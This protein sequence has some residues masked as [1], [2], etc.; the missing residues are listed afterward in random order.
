MVFYKN[1]EYPRLARID[2]LDQWEQ[3]NRRRDQE[4]GIASSTGHSYLPDELGAYSTI[5]RET[6]NGYTSRNTVMSGHRQSSLQ[7]TGHPIGLADGY[8][9]AVIMY[10]SPM[11][12][13]VG[14]HITTA[15]GHSSII[16]AGAGY[17]PRE[18]TYTGVPDLSDGSIHQ[19]I[20]RGSLL[21]R[22]RHITGMVIMAPIVLIFRNVNINTS[23]INN[24][25]Y[26]NIH[27][28]NAVTTLHR[29]TFMTGRSINRRNKRESLSER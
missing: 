2:P 11:N 12:R 5:L 29:D 24:V 16:E 27:V 10:G 4:F 21:P 7:K 8:G 18:A 13:G 26:R 3:W 17:R 19:P 20:Y 9:C 6:V 14:R 22:E 25:V 23:T 15:D 1:T 28:N